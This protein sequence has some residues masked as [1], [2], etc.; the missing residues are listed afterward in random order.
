LQSNR[1]GET[2]YRK[3]VKFKNEFTVLSNFQALLLAWRLLLS[4]GRNEK[5]EKVQVGLNRKDDHSSIKDIATTSNAAPVMESSSIESLKALL[6]TDS[7]SEDRLA[8]SATAATAT[9]AGHERRFV[10]ESSSFVP[11]YST[12]QDIEYFLPY[13]TNTYNTERYLL[14]IPELE[15]K[16]N[17]D[18]YEQEENEELCGSQWS[19]S[20]SS[21]LRAPTAIPNNT[22][23]GSGTGIRSVSSNAGQSIS[24]VAIA[25]DHA[26]DLIDYDQC[27]N[28]SSVNL[29]QN[30][31]AEHFSSDQVTF[32]ES[33][34]HSTVSQRPISKPPSAVPHPAIP[35]PPPPFSSVKPLVP[36]S[37]PQLG[38]IWNGTSSSTLPLPSIRTKVATTT[39]AGHLT[40]DIPD[41]PAIDSE[42]TDTSS[43]T[44][45]EISH[46]T[47]TNTPNIVHNFNNSDGKHSTTVS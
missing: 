2:S 25:A 31:N 39:T 47:P 21:S 18:H 22:L 33:S 12:P 4:N 28:S 13:G 30:S 5:D 27:S 45:L 20:S 38:E 36:L 34:S 37:L 26:P 7:I 40:F 15:I 29:N 8:L 23:F 9:T 17:D 16:M 32:T 10:A 1:V 46:N 11:Q 41:L 14:A 43:H 44:N 35:P 42:D 6:S 19:N 3:H 24:S